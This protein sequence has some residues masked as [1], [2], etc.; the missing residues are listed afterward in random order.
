M[1]QPIAMTPELDG[2]EEP[3]LQTVLY[4][5]YAY[6]HPRRP[7]WRIQVHGQVYRDLPLSL[8]KRWML[9]GLQR[10]LHLTPAEANGELFQSRVHGF[11]TQPKS[12]IRMRVMIGNDVH[13][14]TRRSKR[15]G[16]F[17]GRIDTPVANVASIAE[18]TEPLKMVRQLTIAGDDCSGIVYLAQRQGVSI[19]SDIDDTIKHTDVTNRSKMLER[20]FLESFEPIEGMVDLYQQWA[21]QGCMFHYVSSS[22]WQIYQPLQ[23]FLDGYGFPGG[24]MHLKWFRLRDEI[25]KRW[26]FLRRKN[27]AGVIASLIKRMPQ[28]KFLLIGDS[29]ERDPEIYAKVARRFPDQTIACAIRQIDKRPMDTKRRQHLAKYL[30]NVPLIVFRDPREIIGVI[31]P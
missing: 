22:P 8:S 1:S 11:L 21:E 25:F 10:A 18:P 3:D 28:R 7:I 6:L 24:S 27:K 12:G 23:D 15:S 9:R 30:G 29:G 5:T 14:L 31:N 17:Q 19:I 26:R 20:T 2:I 4:P 13:R 16:I